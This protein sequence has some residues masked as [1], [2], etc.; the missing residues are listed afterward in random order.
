MQE[1]EEEDDVIHASLVVYR[2]GQP[3]WKYTMWKFQDFSSTHILCEINFSLFETLKTVIF[4]HLSSS[5]FEFLGTFDSTK[6]DFFSKNQNS[7]LLQW[8]K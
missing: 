6:C 3:N 7:E 1:T 4:D 2:P 5:K 8:S